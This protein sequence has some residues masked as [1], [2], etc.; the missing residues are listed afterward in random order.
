M[1]IFSQKKIRTWEEAPRYSDRS[2]GLEREAK[3]VELNLSSASKKRF[4]R[5]RPAVARLEK[6]L[7]ICAPK[8]SRMS[9]TGAY[10]NLLRDFKKAS[11]G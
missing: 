11:C 7:Y 1:R 5:S 8:N 4:C 3:P 9:P 10:I 2:E 6:L